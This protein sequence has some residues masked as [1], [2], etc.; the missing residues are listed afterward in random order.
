MNGLSGTAAR[1]YGSKIA[2]P[3]EDRP[4]TSPWASLH[5]ISKGIADIRS[6][7]K[8]SA[9]IAL[10]RSLARKGDDPMKKVRDYRITGAILCP[11]CGR[12]CEKAMKAHRDIYWHRV[13]SSFGQLETIEV[14][15]GCIFGEDGTWRTIRPEPEGGRE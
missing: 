4:V 6:G 14:I 2:L 11:H 13:V 15:D 7:Q 9:R 1:R 5:T 10:V 3:D 12:R 8:V